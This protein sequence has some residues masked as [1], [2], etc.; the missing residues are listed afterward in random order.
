MVAAQSGRRS[1]LLFPLF[2]KLAENWSNAAA[3]D[4]I[5]DAPVPKPKFHV[6]YFV[7]TTLGVNNAAINTVT[8]MKCD[9]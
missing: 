7:R 2:G 1:G 3:L 6:C 8:G 4:A 5:Q 9:L